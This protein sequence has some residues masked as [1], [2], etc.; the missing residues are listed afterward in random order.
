LELPRCVH[1]GPSSNHFAAARTVA[2]A[3]RPLRV[4]AHASYVRTHA[5]IIPYGERVGGTA[6]GRLLKHTHLH[7]YSL[8]LRDGHP[9]QPAA[10]SE[11]SRSTPDDTAA[12]LLR[13]TAPAAPRL[14][15]QEA[16]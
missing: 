5:T 16:P 4:P 9:A 15:N 6:L 11:L 1:G 13:C 7:L 3:M 10:A 8:R 2:C 14:T 12:H